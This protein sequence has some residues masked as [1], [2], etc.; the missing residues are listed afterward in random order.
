MLSY[1][2]MSEYFQCCELQHTRLPCPSPTPG[3]CSNSLSLSKWCHLTVSS[4]HPLLLLPSIFFSIKSFPKCRDFT[5]GG[6][7]MRASASA[8]ACPMNVQNWF[9]LGLTV[10]ISLLSKELSRVFSNTTVWK[11]QIFGA[12]PSL[13]SNSN[14]CTWLME[15]PQLWLYG[16][17][18]ANE[19][20]AFL[21]C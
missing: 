15:K 4:C 16:P 8:S 13:W 5:S 2:I 20:P 21:M 6:Q 1:Y 12:Q 17:L 14:I 19:I 7:I 10:L 9:P 3:A 11:Y 18:S